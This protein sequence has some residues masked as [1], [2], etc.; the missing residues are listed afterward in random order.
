[1]GKAGPNSSE[2]GTGQNGKCPISRILA[3]AS[4]CQLQ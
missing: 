2:E 1:M 4:I 3:P